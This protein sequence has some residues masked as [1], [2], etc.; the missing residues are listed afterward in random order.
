MLLN[1]LI[2]PMNYCI[3]LLTKAVYKS[4]VSVH[5]WVVTNLADKKTQY[6]M[7]LKAPQCEYSNY[8]NITRQRQ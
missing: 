6:Q 4:S 5:T 7:Q 3:Q 1:I 8:Y 2:Q